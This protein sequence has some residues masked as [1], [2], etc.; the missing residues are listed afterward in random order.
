MNKERSFK[1]LQKGVIMQ[2]TY[3]NSNLAALVIAII[4]C[5]TWIVLDYTPFVWGVLILSIILFIGWSFFENKPERP[6]KFEVIAPYVSGIILLIICLL[7]NSLTYLYIPLISLCWAILYH[8][9][10]KKQEKVKENKPSEIKQADRKTI[11]PNTKEKVL[12]KNI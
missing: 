7:F 4:I 8:I 2:L 6:S 9:T 1:R 5:I 10:F 11:T 12:K 3:K